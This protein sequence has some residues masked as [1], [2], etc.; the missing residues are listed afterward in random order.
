MDQI[1]EANPQIHDRP[2]YTIRRDEKLL[3]PA[4]TIEVTRRGPA[5][6]VLPEFARKYYPGWPASGL[7]MLRFLNGIRDVNEI[8][9]QKDA[10]GR[11]KKLKVPLQNS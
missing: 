6:E 11:P 2:R 8:L 5:R 1:W 7:N 4:Q 3:I 9:P 10:S